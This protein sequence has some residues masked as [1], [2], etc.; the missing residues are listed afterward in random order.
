MVSFAQGE[1]LGGAEGRV[2]A[3]EANVDVLFDVNREAFVKLLVDALKVL[4]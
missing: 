1:S 3:A 2:P 4:D